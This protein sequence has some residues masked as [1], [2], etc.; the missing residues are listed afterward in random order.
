MSI[1]LVGSQKWARIRSDAIKKE[2]FFTFVGNQRQ[3]MAYNK[4]KIAQLIH[5]K[6]GLLLRDFCQQH[7]KSEYKTFQMRMRKKKYYPSEV[8]Y[9][10]WLLEESCEKVFG[11]SFWNLVMFQGKNDVPAKV[12]EMWAEADD[13]GRWRMLSLIG[14]QK[15]NAAPKP[16]DVHVP[17]KTPEQETVENFFQDI[18]ISKPLVEALDLSEPARVKDDSVGGLFIETY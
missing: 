9:I 5:K 15:T 17:K 1:R 13:L 12:K 4:L 2:I 10:C 16:L 18:E 11:D 6:T 3:N 7:L 8:V 14:L